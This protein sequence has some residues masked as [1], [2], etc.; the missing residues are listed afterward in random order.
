MP[1]LPHSHCQLRR[2]I[3][4]AALL[5]AMVALLAPLVALSGCNVVGAVA[6][7]YERN[8]THDVKAEYRG[9]EGKSFAILVG[10]DR[11]IQS[12]M[13]MLVEEFTRRM[14]TRLSAPGNVPLP[15][16]FIP[17]SDALAF[18]YRNPTWHLR[19]PAKLAED[20]GGVDR[21]I[22]IELIE[23][24]LHEPG[25]KYVWD[26][27]ASARVSVGNPEN[28]EIDFERVVDVKYPDG[29]SFS[30]DELESSQVMSALLVRLLD[31]ASWLFYDHEEA[32]RPDY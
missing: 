7:T 31:R 26:G 28:D 15:S 32:K 25:N 30:S 27:R 29:E 17:A 2:S 24:R 3:G 20:L 22:M 12:Q 13:P 5:V 9:L 6:D 19:A 14:T 8:A 16:G 23:F 4:V 1:A 18:G 10:A 11:S 21:V